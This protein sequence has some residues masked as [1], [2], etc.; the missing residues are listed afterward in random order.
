MAATCDKLYCLTVGYEH[1]PKNWTLEGETDESPVRLPLT[2]LLV[3]SSDGWFLFDTGLGP[4]F[5]DL[6]FSRKL[7]QWGDPE[8]PGDGD[9]LLDQIEACGVSPSEIDALVMSHFHADH[10]GG[11]RYFADGRPVYAQRAELEFALSPEGA[12]AGYLQFHFDDPKINWQRLDGDTQIA[13]GIR[14]FSTIGH[15]PGHQSFLIDMAESGRWLF[16][17]DAV[18]MMENVE[19][20]APIA[21]GSRE[22]QAHLRRVAHDHVL[23]VARAEGARL[24]PGHCPKLWP[25]LD[26][27]PKHYR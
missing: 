2:A 8:L 11:I 23:E 16:P 1:V 19:R 10:T 20:D 21:V 4:E 15:S 9:P 22:D 17:F 18:P 14:S 3:H 7:Y 26:V 5:R 27:P 25:T 12:A 24:A 13:A 6:E